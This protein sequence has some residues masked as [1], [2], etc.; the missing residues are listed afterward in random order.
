[1]KVAEV[2]RLQFTLSSC[3]SSPMNYSHES[4]NGKTK[5]AALVGELSGFPTVRKYCGGSRKPPSLLRSVHPLLS[6]CFDLPYR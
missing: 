4:K 6:I 5:V 3:I 1:M 2:I